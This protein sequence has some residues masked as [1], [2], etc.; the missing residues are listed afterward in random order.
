M[1]GCNLD[2]GGAVVKLPDSEFDD[3]SGWCREQTKGVK[4]AATTT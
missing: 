3:E 1:N 4:F 2:K